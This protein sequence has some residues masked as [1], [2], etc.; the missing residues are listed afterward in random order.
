MAIAFFDL[1]RTIFAANSGSLWI[2]SELG[3]GHISRFQALR[4]SFW[5]LRYQ[6]GFASIEDALLRAI[7][8]LAG[9][10]EREIRDRTTEFYRMQ[11]RQLFRPGARQALEGHRQQ[12][13]QLVLLTSS[14]NYLSE[15]VSEE[16]KLD[17]YLCNRFEVDARGLHTG[18]LL[19]DLCYGAG[20]LSFAKAFAASRGVAL[21]DCTFYT[22]S[23]S[24][25]PV[26]KAVGRPVAVNPDRRLRAEAR[27][28]GWKVV[29]WGVP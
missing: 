26:L 15:L 17:D 2:K 8:F 14:S 4:A 18:K 16:L 28:R 24:D 7:S 13:D 19:G 29:D 10:G 27:R 20:K 23:F 3:L 11:L 1:D 25:L 6:L 21:A 5:V 9:T 22:D 12:G